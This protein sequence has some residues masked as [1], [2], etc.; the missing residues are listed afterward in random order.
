VGFE[1][2]EDRLSPLGGQFLLEWERRMVLIE[3]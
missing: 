3:V 1:E 2:L